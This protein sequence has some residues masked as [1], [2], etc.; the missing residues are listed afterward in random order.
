[1]QLS[2]N[3]EARILQQGGPVWNAI[4]HSALSLRSESLWQNIA[5]SELHATQLCRASW[6]MQAV[7][8]DH[9]IVRYRTYPLKLAD[10]LDEEVERRD[11]AIEHLL[12]SPACTLDAYTVSLR[13]KWPN[14]DALL[15]TDCHVHI[16]VF[17]DAVKGTTFSTE[18]LHSRSGR[19]V[20]SR[21]MTHR[22]S[23]KD[24]A[25]AHSGSTAPPWVREVATQCK[26]VQPFKTAERQ[27]AP[28][29]KKRG[30]GGSWRAFI[31][32]NASHSSQ[33]SGRIDMKG[34]SQMFRE[35][36]PPRVDFYKRL[37]QLA[38]ENHREGVQAF[39]ATQRAFMAT[40]QKETEEGQAVTMAGLEDLLGSCDAAVSGSGAL[41]S[42]P[43]RRKLGTW[44][45]GFSG[46]Q[47]FKKEKPLLW[48]LG[49][50]FGQK[51]TYK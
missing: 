18:R 7:A 14:R 13:E 4:H 3:A 51:G 40:L 27:G 24:V 49:G 9:L 25:L 39:P 28:A 31:S 11:R 34:A 22:L 15:S 46:G 44:D 5:P 43:S 17:L 33:E 16:F 35:L 6:R 10:L 20:K 37:G 12:Q 21:V 48:N 47:F 36:S 41:T 29:K 38:T 45:C 50:G 2:E 26:E 23:V 30:G 1:M 42:H 19:R 32:H 8:Y